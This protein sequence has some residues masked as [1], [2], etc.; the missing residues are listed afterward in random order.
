MKT[1]ALALTAALA[2]SSAAMAQAEAAKPEA[3]KVNY[4][5]FEVGDRMP[6]AYVGRSY[7][8]KTPDV[9]GLKR[10]PIG[11]R[12]IKVGDVA[13]LVDERND[14][15]KEVAKADAQMAANK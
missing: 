13:Y 14:Q 2:V 15:I 6:G 5:T 3:A 8:L 7:E 10:A 1:L 11:Q 9:Y 4:R 12:W